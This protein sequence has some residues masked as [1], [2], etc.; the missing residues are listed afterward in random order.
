MSLQLEISEKMI[1][2]FII[3][4]EFHHNKF[5]KSLH[6]GQFYTFLCKPKNQRLDFY[7]DPS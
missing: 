5:H 7:L 1:M 2:N 6:Y 3:T 4:F